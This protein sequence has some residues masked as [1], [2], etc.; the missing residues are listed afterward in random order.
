MKTRT[1]AAG[2]FKAKCLALLNEVAE[3]EEI[4]VTKR[5][6]P[7]ARVTPIESH[8]RPSL[9]HWVIWEGDVESPIDVEWGNEDDPILHPDEDAE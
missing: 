6:K 4:I 7:I 8:G 2:E 5:G 9:A 3:G 1:I